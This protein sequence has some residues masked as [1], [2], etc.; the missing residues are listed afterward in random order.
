VAFLALAWL[1]GCRPVAWAIA[2][3]LLFAGPHNLQE[4]RYILGRLPARP[5]KL[6]PYAL[7]S[8]SGWAALSVG[9][10][11][12]FLVPDPTF[13]AR[14]WDALLILW[15][16]TLAQLRSRENPRRSFPWLWP[17]AALLILVGVGAPGPFSVALVYI[18][19][20]TAVWLADREMHAQRHP[21]RVAWRRALPWL[22]VGLLLTISLAL[23]ISTEQLDGDSFRG[24]VDLPGDTQ[25]WL[26]GHVYLECVHYGVWIVL[27]PLVAASFGRH[28]L[29]K[30]PLLRKASWRIKAARV[31]FALGAVAVVALWWAFRWDYA[32][33]RSLYF[34][35]AVGHVLV[36]Y[37]FL[38]RTL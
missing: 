21:W 31:G 28:R 1:V 15:V 13:G 5:G 35:L 26:A 10:I 23:P 36:E 11:S 24:L 14:L 7:V 37:P 38:L 6:W 19:P 3:V 33:T 16:A 22:G 32:A 9:F 17:V 12:L 30:M 25:A 18:H 2:S 29:E 8:V 34:T 20:L 4:A 27:L